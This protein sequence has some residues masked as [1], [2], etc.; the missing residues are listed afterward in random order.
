MALPTPSSSPPDAAS[1]RPLPRAPASAWAPP[2]A[3]RTKSVGRSC[4]A[5][6]GFVAAVLEATAEGTPAESS[7]A[8]TSITWRGS[9][10]SL[11]SD[12]A[13]AFRSSPT[14]PSGRTSTTKK[15]KRKKKKSTRGVTD[16]ELRHRGAHHNSK[17]SREALDLV[18]RSPGEVPVGD[19]AL[20][21]AFLLSPSRAEGQ[22]SLSSGRPDSGRSSRSFRRL[23]IEELVSDLAG[24]GSPRRVE[25]E[26]LRLRNVNQTVLSPP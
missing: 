19:G 14:L 26:P 24:S 16:H 9:S 1:P 22:G 5:S 2:L 11:S 7:S 12:A 25:A 17:N 20:S 4:F 8:S 15:K 21:T 18:R 3:R 13:G 10:V 6:L 23:P